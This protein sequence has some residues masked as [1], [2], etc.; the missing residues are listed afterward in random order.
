MILAPA[1]QIADYTER[2]WWGTETLHAIF[3]ERVRRHADRLAVVDPPNRLA[4]TDGDPLR[5]SWREIGDKTDRLATRLIELGFR[6]DDFLCVQLPTVHEYLVVYLACTR[7][8][9][10]VSP[11]PFAYRE[12]ELSHVCR[13]VEAKGFLTCRNIGGF[14]H[15]DMALALKRSVPSLNH[16]L[17]F[18][19]RVPAGAIA[20]DRE[21]S[22]PADLALIEARA[23]RDALTA[24]DIAFVL[25]T[26]G[27]EAQPKPV[28]RS[29]NNCMGVRTLMTEAA[30]LAEGCHI[31]A[32]RLMNTTGG[33]TGA[34]L[35]WLDR[36][37]TLVLHQPF[38]LDIFLRQLRD[39]AI[40]FASCPPGI[41]HD[42]LKRGDLVKERDFPRLTHVSSGSAALPEWVV[43]E[44]H[45][46]FGIDILNFYGSSEGASLSATSLDLPDAATRAKYFPRFGDPRYR[47]RLT[48][49]RTM[50][51]KL[52]DVATGKPIDE[53]GVAGELCFRG[54]NVFSGYF[55]MPEA[56]QRTFDAEGFYHT[57]DLFEIAGEDGRYFRFV[58]RAKEIIV[59]G[60][61]NI[62]AEEIEGL[63]SEHPALL[64]AAVVGFP[65]E[66]LG[67]KVCAVVVP[68]A[69]AALSLDDIAGYLRDTKKVA[70]YKLPQRLV[71]LDRLPRSPAGKVMK[72]QL[73][74]LVRAEPG[75]I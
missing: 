32:P 18:G 75:S 48:T 5:L 33:I 25:W 15:A 27:T 35:P 72:A 39:E 44:F 30:G 69:D 19:D 7:L 42:L 57:G 58:G 3:A 20:L 34:L 9:I 71:V 64:E 4:F 53:P 2:G 26:S 45:E 54:A 23:E 14:A 40:D 29:H 46:R 13:H 16:V 8:G 28:P 37:A 17:A 51:T 66:R 60:G 41:L 31:L 10:V 1:S 36:G 49:A 59:R 62:S 24:N 68:R 52:V 73:R 6:K 55:R 65:D 43:R 56:T 22:R 47:W 12:H 61:M 74:E 70:V 63:L 21:L 50:D 11:V 67:E 38:K